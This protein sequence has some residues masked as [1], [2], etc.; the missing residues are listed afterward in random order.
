MTFFEKYLEPMIEKTC[1]AIEKTPQMQEIFNGT[2]SDEKFKFQIRQNYQY[3]L[4]YTKCWATGVSKAQG[5]DEMQDW[6]SILSSTMEGTVMINREFWAVELGISVQE[7]ECT[8]MAEGKRSYTS[9]QLARAH[10]GDLAACMMALFPCN[11]LYM[12]FGRHLLPKC[13]L[14]KDDKY[15]KWIEYYTLEPYVKKCENEI[16]MVNKYCE[17]KSPRE[18]ELLLEIFAVSC[19]YEILQWENMYYK[20]QTW[21]LECIFPNKTDSYN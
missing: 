16:R 4:E 2:M 7:L 8:I 1:E 15:Y 6:Y 17:H 21:P 10:E 12:Y 9:H 3:L 19:N 14:S 5:F 13:T 11:I 20:M 18:I